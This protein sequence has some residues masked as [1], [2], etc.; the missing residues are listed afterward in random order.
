MLKKIK[1][2]KYIKHYTNPLY[3][4]WLGMMHRCYHES[5][6]DYRYYGGR[7]IIVDTEWHNFEKFVDDMKNSYKP[8]LSLDRSDND[9]P[10]SVK[11][12][13]W[14]SHKEQCNNR[15]TSRRL[16]DTRQKKYLTVQ[17]ISE[18]YGIN[19][20][21]INSRINVFKEEN[22]ERIIRHPR[23]IRSFKRFRGDKIKSQRD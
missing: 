21:T 1:G 10:Y 18:I 6:R 8:G 22:F 11:N 15:T 23:S 5:R 14:V 2:R 12:C 16:F 13:R 7:G 20:T 9:G 17:E 3:R 4:V 19:R